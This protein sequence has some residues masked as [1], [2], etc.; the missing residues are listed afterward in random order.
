MNYRRGLL[1]RQIQIIE[2]FRRGY[3]GAA[4]EQAQRKNPH[5]QQSNHSLHGNSSSMLKCLFYCLTQ[6][7][8]RNAIL[9]HHSLFANIQT[10]SGEQAPSTSSPPFGARNR[11][12]TKKEGTTL[13][14]MSLILLPTR[15]FF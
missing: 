3:R 9:N 4:T 12:N 10:P 8:S 13:D 15:W 5:N 1:N 2:A 14:E 11:F 6:I 7:W